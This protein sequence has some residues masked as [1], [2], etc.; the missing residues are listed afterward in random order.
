[1]TYS[2]HGKSILLFCL[3]SISLSIGLLAQQNTSRTIA[4]ISF[5]GIEKNKKSY[6]NQFIQSKIGDAP[7]DSL[8]LEDVQRLKN[9][10]SIGNANYVLETV[11]Q[12]ATIVFQIEELKT[13]L[14]IVNFGSVKDN[15]WFQ[16]GFYDINWQGNGSFLSAVYHNRDKR[17]G[18]QIYYR[19]ARIKGS[20]WGFSATLN[21][22]ASLYQCT[23]NRTKRWRNWIWTIFLKSTISRKTQ[24]AF[25]SN[26]FW[27]YFV[28]L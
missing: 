20:D 11:N 26:L 22:S 4:S 3:I 15:R 25:L 9:L 28:N 16:L 27:F 14:P 24:L 12:S 13:L 7:S 2:K 19:A 10:P 8:L 1:M 5:Q 18:G 23:S 17:H 21:K 6:L